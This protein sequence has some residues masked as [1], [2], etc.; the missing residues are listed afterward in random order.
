MQKK[1][2]KYSETELERA[3]QAIERGVSYK[4]AEKNFK[5]SRSVQKYTAIEKSQVLV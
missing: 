4:N 2:E 3:L 1:Y 5:I